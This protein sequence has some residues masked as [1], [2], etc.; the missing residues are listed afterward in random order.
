MKT[1]FT[2]AAV[3]LIGLSLTAQA[4][5][6]RWFNPGNI[7]LA[8]A[9]GGWPYAGA[10]GGVASAPEGYL[11]GMS[12][13][14]R[15]QGEYNE[16]TSRAYM[17]YEDARSKYLENKRQ[18]T[19]IYFAMREENE[20][21]RA[22]RLRRAAYSAEVL[23]AAARSG[24]PKPL[25]S[26]SFNPVTGQLTWPDALQD[27]LFREYRERIDHLMT[28]RTLTSGGRDT[29]LAIYEES[30]EMILVLKSHIHELPANEYIAARKFLDSLAYMVRST[31]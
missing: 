21:R 29:G 2:T 30:Q 17:N 19:A 16:Q 26:E 5:A 31:A 7:G 8:T 18:W 1:T 23:T 4:Q 6:Q 20:S 12:Q 14:I 24:I 25:S 22:E 15:A 13:V 3:M 11:M 27:D 9:Y 28:I 10:V